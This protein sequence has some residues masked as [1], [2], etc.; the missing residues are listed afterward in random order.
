MVSVIMEKSWIYENLWLGE[1]GGF[2]RGSDMNGY[3]KD[4]RL[5]IR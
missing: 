1:Y 5:L 3:L 2:F 4:K